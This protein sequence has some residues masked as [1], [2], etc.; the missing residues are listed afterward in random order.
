MEDADDVQDPLHALSLAAASEAASLELAGKKRKRMSARGTPINDDD[1]EPARKRSASAKVATYNGT[2]ED[3]IESSERVDAEEELDH[4]EERLDELAREGADLEERQANLAAE[5][6]SE[7]ATVAKHT[8]PRK[9]GRRGKRK[10]EDSSYAYTE[11]LTTTEIPDADV[12][13]DD[14]EEDSATLDEEVAK[15]KSAI[16]ELAKIE[17]KFKLFR[18]KL[19]DEQIA[20]YERELEMLKQPDCQHP[21]YVAMIKCIDDRRAEKIDYETTLLELKQQNLVTITAAQRHQMHSQ[22]FQTVR[23][24]REDI[25][26]ECNQRVFELQRGRRSLGCDETEYMIKLPEKRSDQIRQQTAYNLEVSILSGVAKYVGF[27]AAPDISAARPNEIDEDLRAMKI[28]T[29]PTLPAPPPSFRTYS[30]R[31][32][33]DEVAA[34]S[35]FLE[36]TPWAN[37]RHPSHQ[38]TRSQQESRFAPGPSRVASYQTPAGQRRIVDINAPNGSASTIEANSNPPSS[39][40]H[41]TN[42]RIGE[43]ESPVM[44]MKRPPTEYTSYADT[45]GP[46]PRNM[47]ILGR[48][49]YGI[50]SSPAAQHTDHQLHEPSTRHW[51]VASGSPAIPPG[52]PGARPPLTQRNGL[53]MS[54]VGRLL[55]RRSP[56]ERLD[57]ANATPAQGQQATHQLALWAN[58]EIMRSPPLGAPAAPSK[59]GKTGNDMT[60]QAHRINPAIHFSYPEGDGYVDHTH[61]FQEP[62]YQQWGLSG[63]RTAVKSAPSQIGTVN[64]AQTVPV[65]RP[66]TRSNARQTRADARQV[67]VDPTWQYLMPPGPPSYSLASN[68]DQIVDPIARF[69][70][71]DA[72][73]N[74]HQMRNS[75]T[76]SSRNVAPFAQQDIEQYREGPCSENDNASDSGYHT[77]PTRSVLSEPGRGGQELPTDFIVQARNMNVDVV[78]NIS[79]PMARTISQR[80]VSQHSSRSGGHRQ[81]IPCRET[82]CSIISRCISEH[83][84]HMLRHEKKFV[85]DVPDCKREGKGFSTVNDLERHKKSVHKIGI[86]KS[87]SYQ[88][89]AAK[90]ANSTKIWPRLDNFK[91]HLERMHKEEDS[92]ELIKRSEYHCQDIPFVQQPF[93]PV[94]ITGIG[95]PNENSPLACGP[96]FSF[97]PPLSIHTSSFSSDFQ[98][99]PTAAPADLPLPQLI[100]PPSFHG[101]SS[102]PTDDRLSTSTDTLLASPQRRQRTTKELPVNIT[103]VPQIA[104][105]SVDNEDTMPTLQLSNGPQTKSEQQR[106]TLERPSRANINLKDILLQLVGT[107]EQ[108]N[109]NHPNTSLVL[110]DDEKNH[111]SQAIADLLEERFGRMQQ[112]RRST[113][114]S[115]SNIHHC[116]HPDCTFSGRPC[117]LKKHKKRHQRPYGCTYPKCHKRFGA[118]S[119]WKRHENSQHFQLEAFR[120]DYLEKTGENCGHHYYRSAQMQKHLEQEHRVNSK[121]H[122]DTAL[123]RCRIG[124]NCQG[125]FWC[126]FCRKIRPL[127][128]KRNDAWDERFNHIAHHFEK[129]KKPIDDWLCAEENRTKKQLHEEV[130]RSDFADE[131]EMGA[132]VALTAVN[133]NSPVGRDHWS[134]VETEVQQTPVQQNPKKRK[135]T[136]EVQ[137]SSLR[138]CCCECGDGPLTHTI[139]SNCQQ[140]SHVPCKNCQHFIVDD[141]D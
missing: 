132:D 9:G 89:A 63:H 75:N 7:L 52:P 50:L 79:Q 49:T 108:Q 6:V 87:K 24:V 2:S 21:E 61:Q 59:S 11:A 119:D 13:G 138:W 98:V 126:G 73:W 31:T 44:Q 56:T 134:S 5:A 101:S 43:S 3:V 85:C 112:K 22:Y 95:E 76:S 122:I 128:S 60:Q 69:Y 116:D 140:C 68:G 51:G 62:Y 57:A 54:T 135:A 58:P 15:K 111:A 42:G 10:A 19:C 12:E 78:P 65:S 109:S 133:D 105:G 141:I 37:P 53:G 104:L 129:E 26:A 17:K 20:Q 40:P 47:G 25:I 39:N 28:A 107:Q 33:A 110:S 4:A 130:D 55:I 1:D 93:D 14:N 91:Q 80:S 88:C 67:Q 136:G 97:R 86:A 48:E 115:A 83:K 120:C 125:Q 81:Q 100:G 66:S 92:L 46:H 90:C 96:G 121:T 118:K 106:Q 38:E 8:K 102:L 123:K 71:G 35:E 139:Q 45:P 94:W 77:Q 70:R 114:G 124:K 41:N 99:S 137:I 117:D 127:E 82:G 29:R 74:P 30:Q 64:S 72:P 36:S 84:R 18:E 131:P 27:P 34:E 103:P 23:E 113:Q 32:T 16:D